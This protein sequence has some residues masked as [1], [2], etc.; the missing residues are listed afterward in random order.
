MPPEQIFVCLVVLATVGPEGLEEVCQF[1]AP[2]KGTSMHFA[3][4]Y[5]CEAMRRCY[6]DP[7]V[8]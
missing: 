8:R 5:R 4:S 7:S 1:I 6:A 3:G 2:A